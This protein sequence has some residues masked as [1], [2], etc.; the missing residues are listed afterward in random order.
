MSGSS[1][2]ADNSAV[3]GFFNTSNEVGGSPGKGQSGQRPLNVLPVVVKQIKECPDEEFT[4]FGMAAH[5]LCFVGILVRY[6][7]KSTKAIYTIQDH[8]GSIRAMLWLQNNEDND[9]KLPAVKENAYV[10]LFG[11]L[12]TQEDEK[13]NSTANVSTRLECE[14]IANQPA[15]TSLAVRK[16]NPGTELSNSMH[17]LENS[18]PKNGLTPMQ[19]QVHE[20]LR[21]TNSISGTSKSALLSHF[22]QNKTVE[23]M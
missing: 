19:V 16:N 3:G 10:Q 11:T 21:R 20:I 14:R 12:K 5:I 9:Q 2:F 1:N 15:D 7:V 17:F 18:V 23:V 13:N 22:H 8:T 6:E 4:L